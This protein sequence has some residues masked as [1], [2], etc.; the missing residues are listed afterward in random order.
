MTT[1]QFDLAAF[2]DHQADGHSFANEVDDDGGLP[3]LTHLDVVGDVVFLHFD[4]EAQLTW[5]QQV[6]LDG[7]VARADASAAYLQQTQRWMKGLIDEH[8]AATRAGFMG[9]RQR[10]VSK[11]GV[12][13]AE[14]PVE[15]QRIAERYIGRSLA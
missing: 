13:Q 9:K 14:T 11:V 3:A 6:R 2:K 8:A 10:D 15:A 4:T 5:E 7:L 12:D 1:V